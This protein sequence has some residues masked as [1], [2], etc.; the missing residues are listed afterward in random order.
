MLYI[1]NAGL[2][3]CHY[4]FQQP[5][6]GVNTNDTEYQEVFSQVNRFL[7]I[8]GPGIVGGK[9]DYYQ[10]YFFVEISIQIHPQLEHVIGQTSMKV[11]DNGL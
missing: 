6:E 5:A 7:V 11:L 9:G 4:R 3:I 1:S 8:K 2:L 10:C